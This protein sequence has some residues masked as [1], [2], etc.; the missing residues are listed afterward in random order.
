MPIQLH[1]LFAPDR[2]L[3]A[4]ELLLLAV[5]EDAY[6]CFLGRSSDRERAAADKWFFGEEPKHAFSFVTICHYFEWSEQ[7][8]RQKLSK[9][10]VRHAGAPK[11]TI[12]ISLTR[13]VVVRHN[14]V[15]PSKKR[16]RTSKKP[17]L[18]QVK[19]ESPFEKRCLDLLRCVG[20]EWQNEYEIAARFAQGQPTADHTTFVQNGLRWLGLKGCVVEKERQWRR[21]K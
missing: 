12:K 20:K 1:E 2:P 14:A 8:I 17:A 18:V 19:K 6:H 3:R 21:V 9:F 7:A 5:F 10:R 4:E 11:K 16:K 15:L 13:T